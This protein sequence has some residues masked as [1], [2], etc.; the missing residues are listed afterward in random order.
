MQFFLS[1]FKSSKKKIQNAKQLFSGSIL[2]EYLY[3][4]IMMTS[5]LNV[6]NHLTAWYSS[7]LC[8]RPT[9][10][11]STWRKRYGVEIGWGRGQ[12]ETL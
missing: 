1:V 11:N 5:N 4:K 10:Y 7:C 12:M 3:M 9:N 2:I 8:I 6:S